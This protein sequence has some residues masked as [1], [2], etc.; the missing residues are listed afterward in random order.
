[1]RI[2]EVL[3]LTE[4]TE[5]I[6]IEARPMNSVEM[7]LATKFKD[8]CTVLHEYVVGI[9]RKDSWSA[10]HVSDLV[11]KLKLFSSFSFMKKVIY[12]L[13]EHLTSFEKMGSS[14]AVAKHH[15]HKMNSHADDILAALESGDFEAVDNIS[16]ALG[17][18]LGSI[19]HFV[20]ISATA[21]SVLKR[22]FTK[23][24]WGFFASGHDS[25]LD[26]IDGDLYAKVISIDLSK[27]IYTYVNFPAMSNEFAYM[28]AFM[29][30]L[31][32]THGVKRIKSSL[33]FRKHLMLAKAGNES[34]EK[35]T[36]LL[37]DY[38]HGND[39]SLIPKILHYIKDHPEI[40]DMNS[41]AK[42]KITK[43]YRGIASD[44]DTSRQEII[45]QDRDAKLVATS[46]SKYA[47]KNFALAKGHL[48]TERGSEVGY[49]ITYGVEPSDI[50]LVTHILGTVF[51]EAE[52]LIDVTKAKILDIEQV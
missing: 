25:I 51:G 32:P 14:K 6:S 22:T 39:K 43:L 8:L 18:I 4:S 17:A 46:E 44:Y 42:K 2:K 7:K 26:V 21:K 31:T 27:D 13:E 19:D 9:K 35:L 48:D 24:D 40:R 38:L 20:D 37:S 30:G 10:D 11:E 23:E 5:L 45:S 3:V 49:I 28:L 50:V 12:D 16:D 52:V 36:K 41:R 1:M 15:R 29:L 34:Y 33:E 47:A